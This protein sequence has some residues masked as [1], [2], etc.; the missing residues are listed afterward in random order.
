V[1]NLPLIGKGRSSMMS[2]QWEKIIRMTDKENI[3]KKGC[4]FPRLEGKMSLYSE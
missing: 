1:L 3:V 2:G 4:S